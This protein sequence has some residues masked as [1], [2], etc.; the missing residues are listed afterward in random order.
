MSNLQATWTT[1]SAPALRIPVA[2]PP[3]A[4]TAPAEQL[5]TIR[6][7]ALRCQ[8]SEKAIRRAIEAGHLPAVKLCSRIR[9]S[10]DALEEWIASSTAREPARPT[11]IATRRAQRAPAA[12]TFRAL[13]QA[14]GREGELL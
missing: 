12:G 7:V 2:S 3:T 4:S 1:T 6:D 5:L 13:A 10:P 11:R 8:L 9:I 14:Q